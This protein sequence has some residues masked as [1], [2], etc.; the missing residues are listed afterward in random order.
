MDKVKI[1]G[2]LVRVSRL[3]IAVDDGRLLLRDPSKTNLRIKKHKSLPRRGDYVKSPGSH[4]GRVKDIEG[5]N[6][7][8]IVVKIVWE[9]KDGWNWAYWENLEPFEAD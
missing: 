1:A 3:L 5:D 8:G 4:I 7:V 6:G 2:E 9:S